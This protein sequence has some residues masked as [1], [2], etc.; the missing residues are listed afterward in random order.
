MNT[1]GSAGPRPHCNGLTDGPDMFA[2]P[3][4]SR[5]DLG[6]NNEKSADLSKT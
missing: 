2:Q 4:A 6:W 5:K 3:Y 1:D